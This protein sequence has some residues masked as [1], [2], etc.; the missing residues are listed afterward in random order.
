MV[1]LDSFSKKSVNIYRTRSLHILEDD[2]SSQLL[3]KPQILH[4]DRNVC[5]YFVPG[6]RYNV[7]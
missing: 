7:L 6:P 5:L 1:D 3:W 2:S 4:L